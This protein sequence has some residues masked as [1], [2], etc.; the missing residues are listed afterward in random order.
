MT[1]KAQNRLWHLL[2][3]ALDISETVQVTGMR[4]LSA[5]ESC[6]QVCSYEWL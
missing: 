5:I 1:G 6:C 4:L 3:L 2:T